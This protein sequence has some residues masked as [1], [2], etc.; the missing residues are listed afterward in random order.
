MVVSLFL[1]VMLRVFLNLNVDYSELWAAKE[2]KESSQ[3][4]MTQRTKI[5]GNL[6]N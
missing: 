3:L 4:L 6:N 2:G 5:D 1:P